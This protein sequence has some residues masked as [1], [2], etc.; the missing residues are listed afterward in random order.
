MKKVIQSYSSGKIELVEVPIPVC[1]PN[2]IL[3]RNVSSLIS[4]G[5]E[6]S[7]IELGK[8]SLLGK[9]KARPDLVKRFLEKAKNEGFL[10]VF[11]EAL[12]RLDN[13][14]SLGYSS[15]GIVI[16]VGS[17]I[18]KFS[19]GDRVVCI[20]AGYAS[21][22]EY[23]SVPENLCCKLSDEI[24][25]EEAAFGMLGTI[26]LHGIRCGKLSFGEKIAVIGLGL[27][28]LLTVQILKAYGCSVI[29]TDIDPV[30]LNLAKQLGIN[31]CE[32][33][34][35]KK[36]CELLSEG[37]GMDAVLLTVS[38]DSDEPVN[39][40]IEIVKH[41]GRVVLVGVADIHPSRND[42]WHKEV[43]IVVSK[44]GGPGSFDPLYENKGIDYPFVYVRWTENR[45]LEEFIR[46]INEKK[47]NVKSLI[48]HRFNLEEALRAYDDLLN[49]KKESYVGVI[50]QYPE[51]SK[52]NDESISTI[53]R[54]IILNSKNG[55]SSHDI[56]VGVIRSGLYGKAVFLPTLK[57]I[58]AIHLNSICTIKSENSFYTG[59]KYG[60]HKCT[61][62]YKEIIEDKDINSV[63]IL[64][65][66]S[67]HA[68]MVVE[69]LNSGKNVFVEKPLCVNINELS[70]IEEVIAQSKGYLMVG[71]NRR[72]SPHTKKVLTV[73]G[74]RNSPLVINYRINAGFIP[75]THWVHSEEE[76]GN[77]II[78]EACH[79][80]D[81]MQYITGSKPVKVYAERVGG[82]D[83]TIVNDDNIDI[84]IKFLDGS[85]GN[86]FY[87][88]SGDRQ[89]PRENIEVFSEGKTIVIEDFKKTILYL[90]GK[91]SVY[92]TFNQ[93]IGY[94]EEIRHFIEM[95]KGKEK[96]IMTFD[97]IV[98]SSLTTFKINESL[99]K[100]INVSI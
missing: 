60:F 69:S 66:H 61:T 8:Q 17:N 36:Q 4:I 5:T 95:V 34:E 49:N 43:E 58:P 55:K 14:V 42:M 37:M 52:S 62:D 48:T 81:F 12:E 84:V 76:G 29:A 78:G 38:T 27:L 24:T 90:N 70:E 46:L 92:K 45:N 96:P 85:L 7:L 64:S 1:L 94:K 97:E 30:K 59:T 31:V 26:A 53:K 54:E 13:P 3:V 50:F 40:A 19:P 74:K 47:I 57:K 91:K 77:R 89:Y 33:N 75:K 86:I 83:K 35:F 72:F 22:G 56:S 80:I 87:S 28:G 15:A 20:G 32:T 98:L 67:L 39:N 23:I 11:N 82:N 79:F 71:Y 6:K 2:T 44:A 68:Q 65:P 41:S 9:A 63:I 99:S 18:H 25:F 51:K 10:K 100:G 88:A 93:E 21:H 73:L 16:E